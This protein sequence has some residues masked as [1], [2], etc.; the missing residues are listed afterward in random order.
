[1]GFRVALIR[2]IDAHGR[3]P[4]QIFPSPK[5]GTLS[6]TMDKVFRAFEET[7]I[8]C[9]MHTFP[10]LPSEPSELAV[11][12]GELI[13]AAG[14]LELGGKMVDPQTLS[15][16]FEAMTW[17]AQIL[18]SGFL[19]M[20]PRLKMAIFESNAGWVPEMLEHCDRLFKLYA[21]ERLIKADRLPSEA[22][23]EQCFIAFESDE[24]PVFQQWDTFENVGVWSS[25]AYHHDG[26]DSWSAMRYMEKAGVPKAAQA[27]LLGGNARRMYGVEPKLYVTEE[28]TDIQRPDWF[29]RTEEIEQWALA[30]SDPRGNGITQSIDFSKLDPRMIMSAIRAY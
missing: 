19:E 2:P 28:V 3:Y 26:A 4:N 27:K 10:A 25:D 24:E 15:F 20:Y 22:F 11:S 29:P 1:M 21:N 6:N 30:E 13:G 17:L 7:G 8:V 23:R 12:I 18:L 14:S 16:V 9:G 5:N